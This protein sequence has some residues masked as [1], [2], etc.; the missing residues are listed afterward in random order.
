M[1]G[2]T[3]PDSLDVLNTSTHQAAA[4]ELLEPSQSS[5]RASKL[6]SMKRLTI[7]LPDELAERIREAG[8][9]NISAWAGKRLKNALLQ[10]EAV[11]V[12]RYEREH[13]D[14]SWDRERESAA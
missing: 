6:L 4:T 10:E 2:R 9:A 14:R 13:T 12:A 7:A 3:R 8:G 11:A 5:K 1:A